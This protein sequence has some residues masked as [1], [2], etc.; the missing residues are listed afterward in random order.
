MTD[1]A[2]CI[3]SLFLLLQK[4]EVTNYCSWLF[5]LPAA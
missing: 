1:K 5:D 2:P 4:Q 3:A